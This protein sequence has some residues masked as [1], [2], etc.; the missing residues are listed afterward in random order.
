MLFDEGDKIIPNG[1]SAIDYCLSRIERDV[2][3]GRVCAVPEMIN[4]CNETH[5]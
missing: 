3:E 1:L 4:E 2:M 5:F